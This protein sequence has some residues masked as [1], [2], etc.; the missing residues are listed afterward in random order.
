MRRNEA[1]ATEDAVLLARYASGDRQAARVLNERHTPRCFGQA[2]RR[3]ADRAEAEDVAQEA[4]LRL[5]RIAPDW[6]AGEA[7]VSTWLYRVT[8]N[9]CTDRLRRR[10]RMVDYD[11]APEPV[12]DRPSVAEKLVRR[13]RST[14]LHAAIAELPPRQRQALQLRHFDE[15]SNPQ[16]AEIMEISVEAVE[17]LLARARRGLALALAGLREELGEG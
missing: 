16:I 3:L 6:R 7:M 10:G 11:E 12:D 15:M 13:E 5:W 8:Q 9:L 2:Y 17:S 14:A 4:M 1:E